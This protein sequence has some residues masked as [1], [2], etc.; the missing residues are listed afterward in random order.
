MTTSVEATTALDVP[1][2]IRRVRRERDLSQRDLAGLLG[3]SQASI[4]RLETGEVSPRM[5]VFQR[6]LRFAGYRVQVVGSEGRIAAPMD[7]DAVRDRGQRRLP[8]HLD[9]AP[10][11]QF[12][13]LWRIA[14]QG[15]KRQ[16]AKIGYENRELRDA[17]RRLFGTLPDHPDWSVLEPQKP[18]LQPLPAVPECR[19]P[20]ECERWCVQE[21]GCQC[22]PIGLW[23][24]ERYEDL[25][26][27]GT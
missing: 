8:A 20:V 26:K 17:R 2:L 1:G 10:Y 24:C 16:K 22:E 11:G 13:D 5:N 14:W 23:G 12:S 27:Y 18:V 19:C 21:C 4:A 3:L 9:P 7:P 15:A 6:L 25:P